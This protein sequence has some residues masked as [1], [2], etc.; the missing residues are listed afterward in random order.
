MCCHSIPNRILI[1]CG[2]KIVPGTS[3]NKSFVRLP[4]RMTASYYKVMPCSHELFLCAFIYSMRS[5]YSVKFSGSLTP[6]FCRRCAVEVPQLPHGR[7]RGPP[8]QRRSGLHTASRHRQ[9]VFEQRLTAVAGPDGHRVE[10]RQV[11]GW[12]VAGLEASIGVGGRAEAPAC[13]RRA[14]RPSV[15][16]LLCWNFLAL[17]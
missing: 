4:N 12:A 10:A 1:R 13:C 14:C 8:S 6:A 15:S 2:C 7:G 11:S 9:R 16:C 3:F 17:S 5:A